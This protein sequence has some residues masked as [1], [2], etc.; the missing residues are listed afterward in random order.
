MAKVYDIK[1]I[2]IDGTEGYSIPGL[3]VIAVPHKNLK[4][5]D[6]IDTRKRK[7]LCGAKSYKEASSI[8]VRMARSMDIKPTVEV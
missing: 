6:I 7:F 1:M 3:S 2:N 5:F 4:K 8:L